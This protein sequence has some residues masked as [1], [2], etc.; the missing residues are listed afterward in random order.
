MFFLAQES[1]IYNL[2]QGTESFVNFRNFN[3]NNLDYKKITIYQ[4]GPL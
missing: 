3:I 1:N 4:K 2:L